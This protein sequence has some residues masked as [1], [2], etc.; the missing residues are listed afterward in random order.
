MDENKR[1]HL[2][3]IGYE[4]RSTCGRCLEGDFPSPSSP[5]GT[6]RVH[7]YDH[8]KH[9]SSRRQLSIHRSGWCA[10]FVKSPADD[11]GGFD[12]F[13]SLEPTTRREE[14]PMRTDT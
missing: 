9:S 7:T 10:S 12:E 2:N 4:I 5:W 1:R 14:G 8:A 11:L 13:R 3:L 6:C